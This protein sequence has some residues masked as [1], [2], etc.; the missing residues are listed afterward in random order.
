MAAPTILK[1][2]LTVEINTITE[3]FDWGTDSATIVYDTDP[4]IDHVTFVAGASADEL[5]LRDGSAANTSPL[6][7][8]MTSGDG[9]ERT[10][11]FHGARKRLCVDF[12][13]C[14]L[15]TGHAMIVCLWPPDK[16]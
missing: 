5:V 8:K 6:F 12:G 13:D 11:Y 2:R 15:N 3:D 1:N 10:V 16:E 14:T 4:K 7:A 9:E